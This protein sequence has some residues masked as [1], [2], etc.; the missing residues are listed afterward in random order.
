MGT[1]TGDVAASLPAPPSAGAGAAAA[2]ASAALSSV[3][4]LSGGPWGQ[5]RNFAVM[6]GVNAGITCAMKRA[7]GGVEDLQTSMSA[8][9]G[10]GIAF[11]LVSGMGGPNVAANAVST[12][13][14]FS[15]LQGGFYKVG[16][17]FSKPKVDDVLYTNTRG[18]LYSLGLQRYEKNFKQGLLTDDTLQLINDS[19]LQEVRIPPGPRLLI[20]DHIR[21]SPELATAA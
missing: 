1:L 11:S 8:A 7:R 2:D 19:A 13:L 15:L 16:Q 3:K 12:G 17:H 14:A 6:T 5:A 4:A 10:S 18:M 20:L 9:F 21:K